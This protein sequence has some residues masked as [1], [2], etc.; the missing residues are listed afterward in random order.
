[1][2]YLSQA[3]PLVKVFLCKECILHHLDFLKHS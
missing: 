2:A 1:M 3:I